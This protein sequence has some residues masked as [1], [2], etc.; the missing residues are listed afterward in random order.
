MC[1]GRGAADADLA[2]LAG[3]ERRVRGDAAARGQD[4]LGG[5]HAAKVL[6]GRLDADEEGLLAPLL[7]VHGAVGV[8]EDL[9]GG[10]AGAGGQARWR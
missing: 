10:G 7:G 6:G 2:H 9:A 4:A 5:D 1:E 8:E 3:D